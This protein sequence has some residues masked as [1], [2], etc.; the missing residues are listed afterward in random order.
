[1]EETCLDRRLQQ[2]LLARGQRPPLGF[3]VCCDGDLKRH[4]NQSIVDSLQ[5]LQH[6][7]LSGYPSI[8]LGIYLHRR[9][10]IRPTA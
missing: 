3:G 8:I 9:K 7:S 6:I 10:N 1:M 4:V 5:I 2:T